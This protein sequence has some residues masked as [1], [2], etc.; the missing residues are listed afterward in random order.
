MLSTALLAL[1]TGGM[2]LL[3]LRWA[4]HRPSERLLFAYAASVRLLWSLL[5]SGV[6]FT[7][8]T[9][10]PLKLLFTWSRLKPLYKLILCASLIHLVPIYLRYFNLQ[11]TREWNHIEFVRPLFRF[12]YLC[13]F[14]C[15]SSCVLLQPL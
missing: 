11:H 6:V 1:L 4:R 3:P 13:R 12:S 7:L 9:V 15:G 2:L 5:V 8:L 10:K 14:S